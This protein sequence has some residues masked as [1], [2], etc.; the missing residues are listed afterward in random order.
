MYYT[1]VYI[2]TYIYIKIIIPYIVPPMHSLESFAGGLSS[3]GH[4]IAA[5]Q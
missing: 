4:M 3:A 5:P 1:C 2:Y